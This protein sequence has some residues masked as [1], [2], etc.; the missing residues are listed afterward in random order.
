MG[1]KITA[2][3]LCLKA[4]AL[5][6]VI[7]LKEDRRGEGF[8]DTA[9]KILIVVVIGALVLGLIY[10]LWGDIIMPAVTRAITDM[11]NYSG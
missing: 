4:R 5:E 3:Y 9:V 8:V 2:T 10:A 6:K 11:F 7:P 1:N